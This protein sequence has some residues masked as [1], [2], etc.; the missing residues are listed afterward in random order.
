MI[1]KRYF[2][3]LILIYF[4]IQVLILSIPVHTFQIRQSVRFL[5]AFSLSFL[6][7]PCIMPA[8]LFLSYRSH[9]G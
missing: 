9:I 3:F 8:F 4:H 5:F 2:F 6:I 7:L 1:S